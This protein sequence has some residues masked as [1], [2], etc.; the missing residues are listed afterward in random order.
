MLT[1]LAD[2][3]FLT[4][5]AHNHSWNVVSVHFTT[6]PVQ[7]IDEPQV[8]SEFDNILLEHAKESGAKVFTTSRV[9]SL[10]FAAPTSAEPGSIGR[11]IS[12]A[13]THGESDAPLSITY[14]YLIDASGRAGIMS[15]K[16]LKNRRINSNLKNIALW[17]YWTGDKRYAR[18]GDQNLIAPWFEALMGAQF[19]ISIRTFLDVFASQ[20]SLDGPGTFLSTTE[21]HPLV[22]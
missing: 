17:G 8:R 16:Y 18:H 1:K 4:L 15:T 9:K 3:D 19:S 21:Q 6:T 5:G 22:L 7:K 20:M 14:D 11:P 2:T 10:G 13:F 12:A